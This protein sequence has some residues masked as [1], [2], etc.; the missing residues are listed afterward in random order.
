MNPHGLMQKSNHASANDMVCIMYYAM[1]YDLI[2]EV[3][4]KARHE[5]QVFCAAGRT[6]TRLNIGR[7]QKRWQEGVQLA[8]GVVDERA[9]ALKGK[10]TLAI[11]SRI[12][13]CIASFEAV[14]FGKPLSTV[15]SEDRSS[16]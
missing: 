3:C 2:A 13:K 8:K 9:K 6:G 12:S 7:P 10:A 15:T 5:C 4:G 11:A 16:I 1:R 14:T